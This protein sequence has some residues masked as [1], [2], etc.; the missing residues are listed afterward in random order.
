MTRACGRCSSRTRMREAVVG[1]VSWGS[2]AS[3]VSCACP[4]TVSLSLHE[5]IPDLPGMALEFWQHQESLETCRH[6]D[7]AYFALIGH[8][9]RG[10]GLGD[11]RLADRVGDDVVGWSLWLVRPPV[12]HVWPQRYWGVCPHAPRETWRLGKAIGRARGARLLVCQTRLRPAVVR[13]LTGDPL[14]HTRE[15][16]RLGDGD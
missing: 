11:A 9:D 7:R 2:P 15:V 1:N 4:S 13:R 16:W 10:P 6:D 5:G 8:V 12:L 14:V 3:A